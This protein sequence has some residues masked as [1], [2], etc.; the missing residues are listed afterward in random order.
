MER[1]PRFAA[2]RRTLANK[3]FA[4]LVSLIGTWMQRVAV[5]WLTWELTGSAAW[6]GAVAAA[7]FMPTIIVA[8][9]VGALAD[10]F[11]RWKRSR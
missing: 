7:E 8:P 9:V 4:I 10:R 6:L 11:D 3:N 1:V 5:G 2:F